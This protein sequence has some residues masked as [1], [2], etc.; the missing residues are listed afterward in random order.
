MNTGKMAV[1][2]MKRVALHLG[3]KIK[4]SHAMM[5][6]PAR[7]KSL[8][9]ISCLSLRIGG[10]CEGGF[11]SDSRAG[12]ARRAVESRKRDERLARG[13]GSMSFSKPSRPSSGG[14]ELAEGPARRLDGASEQ[15]VRVGRADEA[16]LEL[17]GREV[18]ALFEHR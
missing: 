7:S 8:T 14:R 15:F 4:S 1:R 2:A 17:R 16:G 18:D 13:P 12:R 3:R 5:A 6:R 9:Y 10:C 11:E